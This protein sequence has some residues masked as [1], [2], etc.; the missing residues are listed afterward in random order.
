MDRTLPNP[1][2]LPYEDRLARLT[3]IRAYVRAQYL[4]EDAHVNWDD[5]GAKVKKLID[6][7]I[8]ANVRQLMKPVSV[9]DDD[10][11]QKI[12]T[13]PHDEAR[14]SVMEH[15]IRAYI[16][17]RLADNPMFYGKLSE[18]LERIISDLRNQVIDAAEAARRQAELKRELQTEED[19][20]ATHGLSPVSFAVYELIRDGSSPELPYGNTAGNGIAYRDE[21]DE[22]M[23]LV[24]MEVEDLLSR[25]RAVV[26]WQSNPEVQREMRRDIKRALRPT[27]EYGEVYLD[28][29]ANRIVDMSRRRGDR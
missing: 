20:A 21:L 19:V 6:E 11:D 24:S 1:K 29:L 10:F 15:A 25:H 22:T 17:D 5:I 2:A 26:D 18:Q 23:K 3:A 4:R 12:S 7:R 16:S 13:L 28:A 14:A 8:D 9:L 27:G